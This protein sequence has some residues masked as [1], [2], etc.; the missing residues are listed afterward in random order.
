VPKSE[1]DLRVRILELE[2]RLEKVRTERDDLLEQCAS[3]RRMNNVLA[4]ENQLQHDMMRT[5]HLAATPIRP[6]LSEDS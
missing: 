3:L 1:Q 6:G 2:E 5:T 4:V